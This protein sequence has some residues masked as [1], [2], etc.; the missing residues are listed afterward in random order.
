[1]NS[2]DENLITVCEM[3]GEFTKRVVDNQNIWTCVAC[4]QDI[5][6]QAKP[7]SHVCLNHEDQNSQTS[8]NARTTPPLSVPN[9]PFQ[10]HG[11]PFGQAFRTPPPG[12]HVPPPTTRGNPGQQEMQALFRFQQLQAEQNKQMMIFLQQQNQEMHK[13]QQEQ[14]ELKM[15]QMMEVLKLQTMQTKIKC[16]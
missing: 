1:M 5:V 2:V 16:P 8:R 12:F 15:N 9:S 11:P 14:N 3:A 6:S 13:M 7:R 10:S 4:G